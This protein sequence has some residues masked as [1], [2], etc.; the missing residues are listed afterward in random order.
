LTDVLGCGTQPKGGIMQPHFSVSENAIADYC[1]LFVNRR[2]YTV[3][4]SS[5]NKDV[6]KCYYYRANDGSELSP[7]VI[8][9][10]LEGQITV[11]LYA[12]NPETQGC[13]WIAI[14]AD[15]PRALDDL[16]RLQ[17][18][19]RQDGVESALERSRRGGHLW[20]F[21]AE[22]LL[23]RECRRYIYAIARRLNVPVRGARRGEENGGEVSVCQEGIEL[24]PKQDQLRAQEFGNALRAPLGIHRASGRRYWFYG[25]DYDLVEQ[26]E[27]LKRL[28]KVSREQIVSGL[29][30]GENDGEPA[31]NVYQRK[32]A[33][34]AKR[35]R[36]R[37]AEEFSILAEIGGRK[38]RI[39]QNYFAR[40]PSCAEQGRDRHGD[41]LAISVADPRKYRCWA[42]CTKEQ[43]RAALG[44]PIAARFSAR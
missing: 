26:I 35:C 40:C 10:H 33:E 8:R 7:E 17:W 36:V 5:A 22:P 24:F 2:E 4:V 31:P 32:S 20:I 44:R 38:R 11:G 18:E 19:L 28:K 39:G 27:Y 15:Y 12:I 16:L 34:P 42:G 1:E 37:Q 3:Q 9:R 43:I 14:D 29:S 30:D 13:K 41:N 6:R 23:A 25:A 21:A